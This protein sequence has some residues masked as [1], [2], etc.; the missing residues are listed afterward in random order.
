MTEGPGSGAERSPLD[1]AV[2]LLVYAPLGLA[3]AARDELPKLIAKGRQESQGQ[4]AMARV[5]GRFAVGRG[6]KEASRLLREA[7]GRLARLG[8]VPDPGRAAKPSARPSSQ[9]HRSAES[10]AETQGGAAAPGRPAEPSA[11]PSADPSSATH[12]PAAA[13]GAT[14]GAIP[15]PPATEPRGAGPAAAPPADEP[16][17]GSVPDGLAIPGY[18]SLSA[19]HVV[20][21]LDGLSA[22]EL[23]SVRAYE[24][25][26]RGR[27]TILSRIAQLQSPSGA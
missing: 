6:Q 20:Q 3:L 25:A 27:K 10:S 17:A 4:V 7:S 21:R 1:R 22:D 23:E 26:H 13:P 24:T 14:P 12:G 2:D 8:L 11:D 5:V 19:P 9:T 15:A 16:P 18:D